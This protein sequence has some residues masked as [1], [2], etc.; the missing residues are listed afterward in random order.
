MKSYLDIL[1]KILDEGTWKKNRTGVDTISITGAMFE[2]DLRLGFPLLTTKK[3]AIKSIRVELEGFIKG[4]SSKGWYQERGCPFWNSWCDPRIVPYGNDQET[5]DKMASVD[6][7]GRFYPVQWRSWQSY[8]VDS[9]GQVLVK[10]ID[11]LKNV[12]DT[13]KVDP[14][15][16]RMMVNSWNVADLDKM[17]LPPCHFNWEVLSDGEHVDLLFSMRSS[18]FPVGA[19]ANIAFY[20][21]L[22]SLIGKECGLI[23]RKLVAFLGD[24]HIYRDQLDGVMEQLK[25]E[26]LPLPTIELPGFTSIFDWTHDQFELK[27]Y[28]SHE[29]IIFPVA[30]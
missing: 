28:Q 18:D 10:E 13:L 8:E 29:K 20:A 11:Q 15:N 17:S 24:V 3:M 12:I 25:R 16:R 23:P 6:E 14:Y 9:D 7:L 30:V 5:K 27:N 19:P 4:I 22:L 2:H 1:Q 26:P 21:I